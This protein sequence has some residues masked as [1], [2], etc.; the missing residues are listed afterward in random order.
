MT[1]SDL[2]AIGPLIA[3]AA[4]AVAAMLAA[5]LVRRQSVVAAITVAGLVAA[6][7]AIVPAWREGARQVTPLLIIDGYALFFTGLVLA[8]ALGTALLAY[9]YLARRPVM[10]CE[11]YVL[12]VLATLGAAVLASSDHLASF[13]LGLEILTVS[14]YAMVGYQ[15]TSRQ[16]IEAAIK[17]LVL[18]GASSAFLLFGMALVYAELGTM[19]FA[20]LGAM[21]STG[22]VALVGIGMILVG[23]GFKLSLAPFHLWAADVYQGAPAPV[24]AFIATVS[25][26]AVMAVLLRYFAAAGWAASAP[27]V[28]I[29]TVLA[30]ASM[31]VGNLLALAQDNLKRLLAYSSIAHMGYLLVALLAAGPLAAT[32]V[33]YYLTAYFVT[34]LGAL[35]VLVVLSGPDREAETLADYR[36]LAWR[37]PVLA[38][39]LV[40]MLLSLA[41]I[42][43]TA[44]FVGKFYVLAAGVG[45]KLWLL[46]AALAINSAIGLYYYL[47]VIVVIFRPADEAESLAAPVPAAALPLAGA[48][49]LAALVLAL[50]YLGVQPAPMIDLIQSTVGHIFTAAAP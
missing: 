31:F 22:P 39:V 40:A 1:S 28:V 5:P 29:L 36:G 17:Y 30:V 32:A 9:D 45:A 19:R 42:P 46:V 11:F 35:G 20:A 7:V 49:V 15:R 18:G 27:L 25:K 37:R 26:G 43:V 14:L 4:A 6:L 34:M 33:A 21:R 38:G 2:I 16:G 23:V 44:G 48:V 3:L 13:F 41:G 10:R 8:A 47:R 12:L 50:V 24:T